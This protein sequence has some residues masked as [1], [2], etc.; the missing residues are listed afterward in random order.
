MEEYITVIK[1]ENDQQHDEIEEYKTV[2]EEFVDEVG[3]LRTLMGEKIAEGEL[4]QRQLSEAEDINN[5]CEEEIRRL[6]VEN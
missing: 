3:R 4:L 2:M 1:E 5:R 6:E